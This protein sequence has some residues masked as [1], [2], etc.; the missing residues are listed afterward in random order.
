MKD[1]PT[2]ISNIRQAGPD[3]QAEQPTA[4][5]PRLIAK[6]RL[7]MEFRCPKCG[8]PY[9]GAIL[10]RNDDLAVIGYRC[11]CY[12]DGRSLS[13]PP[14]ATDTNE[15]FRAHLASVRGVKPCGW[16]GAG[17]DCLLEEKP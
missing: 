3:H 6:K 11:D 15:S 16:V 5:V 1:K 10:S 7:A 8:G 13:L 9:G 4:T 12:V 14:G 17:E 2:T